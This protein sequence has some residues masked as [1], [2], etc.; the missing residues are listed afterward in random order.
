MFVNPRAMSPS[1]SFYGQAN[2]DIAYQGEVT[3]DEYCISLM[4]QRDDHV[5]T[6]CDSGTIGS[7]CIVQ[8]NGTRLAHGLCWRRIC[9]KF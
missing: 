3:M 6:M 1:M 9:G 4:A 2:L 7:I 5:D 8:N